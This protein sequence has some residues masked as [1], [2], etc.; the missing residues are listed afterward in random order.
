M[1]DD[2]AK[3]RIDVLQDD[4]FYWGVARKGSG[5]VSKHVEGLAFNVLGAERAL[6]LPLYREFPSLLRILDGG[7]QGPSTI[8]STVFV[9][10]AGATDIARSRN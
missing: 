1:T 7:E 6:T 2:E 10:A 8:V 4:A 3:A 9:G 5:F